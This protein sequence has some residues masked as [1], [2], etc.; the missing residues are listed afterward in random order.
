MNRNKLCLLS[1]LVMILVVV[2]GV[3]H[4]VTRPEE[5]RVIDGLYA[6]SC[7]ML[8]IVAAVIFACNHERKDEGSFRSEQKDQ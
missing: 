3:I 2:L 1:L 4:A 7:S 8:M 5:S 6:V